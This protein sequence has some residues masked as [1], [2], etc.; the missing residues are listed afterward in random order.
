M[1]E[2]LFNG[3]RS[4]ATASKLIRQVNT[5]LLNTNI[6]SKVF[7]SALLVNTEKLCLRLFIL[8]PTLTISSKKIF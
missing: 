2:N 4:K 3:L 7:K 5:V 8:F 1:N 6:Q